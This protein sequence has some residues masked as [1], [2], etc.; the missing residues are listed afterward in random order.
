MRQLGWELA[1]SGMALAD[2]HEDETWK[3]N[4]DRAIHSLAAAGSEF[5]AEEVRAIAGSPS[6]P[7]AFGARFCAASRRGEIVRVGY[8]Q[9]NR[10]SRHCHPIAIWR[11]VK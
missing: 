9:A 6:R 2:E 5:T 10:P 1:V 7:N 4:A 3:H 11:G 8:R